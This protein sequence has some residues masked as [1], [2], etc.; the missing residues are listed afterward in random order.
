M[1]EVALSMINQTPPLQADYLEW[2]GKKE[3]IP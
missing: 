1:L 2:W 3:L